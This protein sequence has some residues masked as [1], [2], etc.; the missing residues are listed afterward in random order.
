MMK[1]FLKATVAVLILLISATAL[2]RIG[3][4]DVVFRAGKA[5]D[6][7]FSHERHV[8]EIGLQCTDCHDALY[9]TREAGK[10]VTM[11]QMRQGQSCGACHDGKV[12]FDVKGNCSRCHLR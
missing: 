4:G 8:A 2:A 10:R 12:A 11:A 6:A 3:G 9:T 1:T 7:H 5:K